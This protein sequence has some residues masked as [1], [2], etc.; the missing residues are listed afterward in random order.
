VTVELT[1]L[2][3]GHCRG[4]ERVVRR[5]GG[6]RTVV[7]PS[8]VGVIRHPHAGVIL[9]DTGY[10]PRFFTETARFPASVYA[11][12]TP[13]CCAPADT[14]AA[15]LRRAGIDPGD[16]SLILISH[17]HAD[18]VGGL[19][20]FPAARFLYFRAALDPRWGGRGTL[21]AVRHGFLPGLLPADFAARSDFA[22]DR[23][24]VPLPLDA[25]GLG[26]GRDL[27][28]D[29][30]L[31]AVDLSGHVPGQLGLLLHPSRPPESLAG[32][33]GVSRRV[34][35]AEPGGGFPGTRSA[36]TDEGRMPDALA[37]QSGMHRG[38]RAGGYG[39]GSPG[40]RSAP[41]DDA[42]LLVG[43]ACWSGRAVTHEELPHPLARL[44]TSDW[45]RYRQVIR[46]LRRISAADDRVLIVPSHC[47]ASI[48]RARECLAG[49]C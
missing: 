34:Q 22:D 9:Y 10:T 7:L 30:S 5:G 2:T 19:R 29:G 28:G 42:V 17:F 48:A 33:S 8:L 36:P 39:G 27:L 49:R 6:W 1:L 38:A 46:E 12:L 40:K 25:P 20:D 24:A 43:D 35:A 15:Q 32:S 45:P 47:A 4:P 3:A 16:V 13:A 23:P 41:P 11:R 37:C 18:H 21:R 31:L 44:V 26:L 14:A